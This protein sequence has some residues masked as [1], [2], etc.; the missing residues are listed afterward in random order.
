MKKGRPTPADDIVASTL[1]FGIVD[2]LAE[3]EQL[4]KPLPV[5]LVSEFSR[6]LH[7]ITQHVM[8]LE[9]VACAVDVLGERE[10]M[11]AVRTLSTAD[12]RTLAQSALRQAPG[13]VIVNFPQG[14]VR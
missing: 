2:C 4:G 10:Y 11:R 5:D 14:A 3:H 12:R 7:L 9:A 6:G 1:L 13:G 8:A